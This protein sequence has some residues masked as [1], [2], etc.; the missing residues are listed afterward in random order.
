MSGFVVANR[1][2]YAGMVWIVA[3]SL[4]EP[5]TA[6]KQS[7]DGGQRKREGVIFGNLTTWP[8]AHFSSGILFSI[9]MEVMMRSMTGFQIPASDSRYARFNR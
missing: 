5:E 4:R 3:F 6:Q 1:F 7:S 8:S 2:C 9:L